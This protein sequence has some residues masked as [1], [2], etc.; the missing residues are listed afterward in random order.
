MTGIDDSSPS[1]QV[2]P[3]THLTTGSVCLNCDYPLTGLPADHACPECGYQRESLCLHCGYRLRGLPAGSVCPECGVFPN[4]EAELRHVRDMIGRPLIKLGW[5]M[6]KFWR[7]LPAG[8]WWVL[9]TPEDRRR[10]RARIWRARCIWLIS[11]FLTTLLVCTNR[12]ETLTAVY[13]HPPG[14]PEKKE[15]LLNTGSAWSPALA[16]LAATLPNAKSGWIITTTTKE[17]IA[18]DLDGEL[19]AWFAVLIG[20]Y[21]WGMWLMLRW[22]WLPVCLAT[23]PRRKDKVERRGIGTAALYLHAPLLLLLCA[24]G[25]LAIVWW[26]LHLAYVVNTPPQGA[27]GM[28]VTLNTLLAGLAWV[29]AI[30]SDKTRHLFE[31]RGLP[32]FG[33][34]IAAGLGPYLVMFVLYFLVYACWWLWETIF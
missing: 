23:G 22:I 13:Q 12:R 31:N 10:A 34:I 28:A 1:S 32:I 4:R 5:R 16:G 9:D 3:D 26:G 25:A 18:H 14:Q 24:E 29:G 15:L 11:L 30:R 7:P 8:F 20:A 33:V 17:Q 2:L 21:S 6:F 19:I 27:L